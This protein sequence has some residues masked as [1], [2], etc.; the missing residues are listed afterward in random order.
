MKWWNYKRN[1]TCS[2]GRSRISQTEGG[3][4]L[5]VWG[6]DQSFSKIFAKAGWEGGASLANPWNCQCL[7]QVSIK[8][9]WSKTNST[10]PKTCEDKLYTRGHGGHWENMIM[11][12]CT[13]IV[14]QGNSIV[15]CLID[16]FLKSYIYL[17]FT[18]GVSFDDI[19]R[20][21]QRWFTLIVICI[22]ALNKKYPIK[23][24][25]IL[26]LENITFKHLTYI[27]HDIYPQDSPLIQQEL[28]SFLK[29]PTTHHNI[30]MYYLS[31]SPRRWKLGSRTIV[32]V[33]LRNL[34]SSE[35]HMVQDK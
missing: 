5:W 15:L 6:E 30:Y 2:S 32:M 3:A 1:E 12:G 31:K 29:Y 23:V 35:F 7:Q 17:L 25:G 14:F 26:Y 19:L 21:T 22:I 16:S 20:T 11:E 9:N 13:W 10:P 18:K 4:N 28:N 33:C 27:W 8:L 34:V 24:N